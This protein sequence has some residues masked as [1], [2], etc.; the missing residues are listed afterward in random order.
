MNQRRTCLERFALFPLL[1]SQLLER[2]RGHE[3]D[4]RHQIRFFEDLERQRVQVEDTEFA[5][6]DYG[7]D[8]IQCGAVI[9]L[10]VLAV[11]DEASIDNVR[12]EL[13]PRNEVVVLAV[14]FAVLPRTTRICK[15]KTLRS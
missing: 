7:S 3:D 8:G 12:L 10:L 4:E 14:D 11:L 6:V 9:G 5:R 15:R 2:R 1:G 13:R